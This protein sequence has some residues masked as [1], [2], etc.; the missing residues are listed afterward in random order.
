MCAMTR[1][2]GLAVQTP[3]LAARLRIARATAERV[4]DLPVGAF[5]RG[6]LGEI[7]QVLLTSDR[8]KAHFW[9]SRVPLIT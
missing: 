3:R 6:K 2:P 5:W 1:R 4:P 7:T 8:A 9:Q